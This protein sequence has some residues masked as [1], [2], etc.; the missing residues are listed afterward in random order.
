M[1]ANNLTRADARERARLLSVTSYDVDLD[2]TDG[3]SGPSERTFRSTSVVRFRCHEAGASTFVDLLA[4][5]V[6]K[7]ILNGQELD[8]AEVYNGHAITLEN[9]AEENELTVVAEG[10]YMRTGEGLHR[11]RDP[12]DGAVYVY[13]QF[14]TADAHRMYACFD[15]P[16]LKAAFGLTV[17][18]PSEWQVVSTTTTPE[19]HPVRDGIARW[20]FQ[21]SR[22]ISTYVTS[23]IAGPYFRINDVYNGREHDIPLGLYCRAS[24]AEFLDAEELF[25]LTKRGFAFFEEAFDFPYPFEKYDQLF[26]PEF[27]AGA[28]ENAGAVTFLEDYVFR[29][30]VTAASYER[31]AVTLLHEMAHMWFGDLVTMRWW[32]DLWLNESF[33]EYV[34]TL[35]TQVAT[36]YDTVWASFA[37][38]EKTWAYR[39][40][41]LPSTHPIASD[42]VDLNAVRA[43][44]DGITYAKGA[45]VLKQLVAWVGQDEFLDGVRD[46]FQKHAWGNTSLDDLLEALE[47]TSGRDLSSWS[48]EWLET[49][50]VNTLRAH[51]ETDD[52]DSYTAFAVMQ[53]APEQHP[54]LRSH[55]I[56]IG[57]YDLTDDGLVRRDRV[58]I[59]ITGAQSDVPELVGVRRP[60]LL[61]LNDDDL[62]YA[63]IRLDDRSLATVT[64]HIAKLPH[65]LP[66]A[67][68]WAG[69]WDMLR[70]AEMPAR[71]YVSLVTR[72]IG[73]ESDIGLLQNHLRQAK[74]ACDSFADPAWRETGLLQLATGAYDH[75]FAAEPGSDH[76][77]AWVRA[78]ASTATSEDHVGLIR[79]LLS[80]DR[81]V[82][83]LV[84]D[85]DLRW[86]F[87]HR[88][89]ALEVADENEIDAE[90]ARDRTATG[91]R[92]AAMVRAARPTEQAK[93][94]AWAA[95]V[96]DDA[97]PNALQRS[98]VVGFQNP[99]HRE[100]LRPYVD[101][102]FASINQ[103]WETRTPE[104][105][106]EIIVNLFPSLVIEEQTLE[107]A[108]RWLRAT[109]PDPTLRRLVVEGR[110]T[111]ERA[112]KA[113]ARDI[114]AG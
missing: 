112:L 87:L 105:A 88:L 85:V 98:T 51:F 44:F 53:E 69:S 42:M 30:K 39:Q 109:D 57:L 82:E 91:E 35:A 56:A 71:D 84:V 101:R 38:I 47:E 55:R 60:D 54:T 97:L 2:L 90:L 41:Q 108:D 7:V 10:A 37:N 86:A 89:V 22:P 19:P 15:Q 6:E 52:N 49:A 16:D 79:D 8:P 36:R 9:L 81:T 92:H 67:I 12:V 21:P 65:P 5:S 64:E 13:S 93:A 20:E 50:G 58:E 63:K 73:N 104:M 45:S 96:D 33:A 80:G 59:D 23:L 46:Y 77:L 110:A 114:A 74:I 99:D 68:C 24:L 70:D 40:D 43:N 66:R 83:G 78:L 111:T 102:Y 100:L 48:K 4:P 75:V 26:V 11:F 95:V 62:T 103:L 18:A 28:M 1:A 32:D 106:Q 76:Q 3:G 29:S 72:G 34:S 61:L 113:R 107:A 14:E 31:R 27:N 25:D 17:T 94:D